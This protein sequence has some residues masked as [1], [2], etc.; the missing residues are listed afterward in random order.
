[1]YKQCAVRIVTYI[2][3]SMMNFKVNASDELQNIPKFPWSQLLKRDGAPPM[4]IFKRRLNKE[5]DHLFDQHL[6]VPEYTSI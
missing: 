4:P 6:Q 1:M 5:M 2:V 3:T